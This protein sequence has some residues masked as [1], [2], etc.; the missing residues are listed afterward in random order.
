M[1]RSRLVPGLAPAGHRPDSRR[2]GLGPLEVAI[3][4]A[5]AYSDVFDWPLSTAEIHRYLPMPARLADVEG[6]VTASSLSPFVT[7]V[8]PFH[9]LRGRQH[10]V[11][12]RE[13]KAARSAR[14]WSQ[15]VRYGRTLAALPWV[16]LV[17][18]TGS[19]AVG[20]AADDADIDLFIV[21][22][23]GRL[24][25]ARAM[26][27][28]V[29]KI[30]MRRPSSRGVRLCPNYL[31]TASALDLPERDLYTAHELAQLV[32]LFGPPAY[33]T[34]MARNTWYQELLPN[35]PGHTGPIAELGRRS[36]NDRLEPL[37]ANPL[38]ERVE[39][40][41][42]QRKIARLRGQSETG[43]TRFDETI[44]KGH[45]EGYRDHVL[46]AFAAR[47]AGLLGAVP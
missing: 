34:L 35:H 37:L 46:D 22:A 32:P 38:V 40:W 9:V 2:S 15:A 8:G 25:L 23:D 7:A 45:F 5:L 31:L 10:L 42:R 28:G 12:E 18:V 6:A 17:A 24:W 41:E 27:I 4:E 26:T 29:A 1:V 43:E 21:A 44:C 14:L 47:M 16:R 3:V 30:A 20:A 19:L 39:R 36:I 13:R 33:R 11:A